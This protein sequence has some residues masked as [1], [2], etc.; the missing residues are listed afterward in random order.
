MNKILFL[1]FIGVVLHAVH[2]D[3]LVYSGTTGH[4]ASG[5]LDF[6]WATHSLTDTTSVKPGDR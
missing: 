4:L 1:V 3:L 6:S 5:W 2:A